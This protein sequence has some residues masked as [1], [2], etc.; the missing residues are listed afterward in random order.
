MSR[1]SPNSHTNET[2]FMSIYLAGMQSVRTK[3]Q[4]DLREE[5]V[6]RVNIS[7]S[8]RMEVVGINTQ[9]RIYMWT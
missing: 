6:K 9:L 2:V 8:R 3:H 5:R 7:S 1:N 4:M